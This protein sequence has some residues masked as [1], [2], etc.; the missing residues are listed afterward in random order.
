MDP[1]SF[2]RQWARCCIFKIWITV[3]ANGFGHFRRASILANAFAN[4]G[5]VSVTLQYMGGPLE[6]PPFWL[7]PKVSTT[8]GERWSWHTFTDLDRYRKTVDTFIMPPC[9][10]F[11]GDNAGLLAAKHPN[12]I[13]I[14][15]FLFGEQNPELYQAELDQLCSSGALWFGDRYFCDPLIQ[16]SANFIDVGLYGAVSSASYTP[17]RQ[18]VWIGLGTASQNTADDFR[19]AIELVCEIAPTKEVVIGDEMIPYMTKEATELQ[20]EGRVSKFDNTKACKAELQAAVIRPGMGSITECLQN[21]T[22]IISNWLNTP[23]IC[24]N[25]EVLKNIFFQT[26]VKNE[27]SLD[28]FTLE[29]QRQVLV[30]HSRADLFQNAEIRVVNYIREN[31]L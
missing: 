30:N 8:R 1:L 28:G 16:R 14:G 15:D 6:Q 24:R 26:S 7:D 12:A 31:F 27:F 9:D 20:S 4:L 3:T 19:Q 18:K 22:P 23:E 2:T 29:E 5:G 13:F 17:P 25:S 11:I 10:L 21:K